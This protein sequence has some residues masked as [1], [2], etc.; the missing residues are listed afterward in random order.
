MVPW[1]LLIV[2]N[3]SLLGDSKKGTRKSH[4]MGPVIKLGGSWLLVGVP[5]R[6]PDTENEIGDPWYFAE[7]I[8]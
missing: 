2:S 7:I 6:G 5:K 1:Y 3:R 8:K 4:R